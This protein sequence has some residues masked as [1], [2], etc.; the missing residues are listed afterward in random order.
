MLSRVRQVS[1]MPIRAPKASFVRQSSIQREKPK[2][3]TGENPVFA[4]I[5]SGLSVSLF[6]ISINKM[7]SS[8]DI[9]CNEKQILEDAFLF[10]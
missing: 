9:Q 6:L 3:V 8:E 1:S 5:L 7:L 10:T 4:S 2:S